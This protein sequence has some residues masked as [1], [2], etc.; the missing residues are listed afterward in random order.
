MAPRR[1]LDAELVRRA[2]VTSRSKAIG[3]LTLQNVHFG[4]QTIVKDRKSVV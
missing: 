3:V 4:P 1:R 2:L